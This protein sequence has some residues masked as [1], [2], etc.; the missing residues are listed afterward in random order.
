[1]PVGGRV[2]GQQM[3]RRSYT[4]ERKLLMASDEH[5]HDNNEVNALSVTQKNLSKHI[6]PAS[7]WI[8]I[9]S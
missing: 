8:I 2:E 3:T 7:Q 4:A 6:I 1:M 9:R 5:R